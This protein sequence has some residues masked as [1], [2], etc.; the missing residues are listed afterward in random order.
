MYGSIFFRV[1]GLK[2]E[3]ESESLGELVKIQMAG[4]HSQSF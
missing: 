1:M 2:L 3:H 4:L